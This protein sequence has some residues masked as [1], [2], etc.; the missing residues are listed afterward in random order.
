MKHDV[1]V[2][3][4]N[5]TQARIFKAN[6]VN[7]LTELETLIHPGSRLHS[8]DLTSDRPGRSFESTHS[9]T[10]HAMEPKT[11][12]QQLEFEEFAKHLSKHLNS[13]CVNGQCGKLYLA[14]SPAFLGLLR[15]HLSANTTHLV[16]NQLDKDITQL[17]PKEITKHFDIII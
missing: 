8:S 5:S 1:W 4:A 17:S 3:V 10:R 6:T 7:H 16:A 9:G 13:A 2:V 15:Q 11:N 12:P 14:A